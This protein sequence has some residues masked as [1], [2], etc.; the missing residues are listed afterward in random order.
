MELTVPAK[1]GETIGLDILN[2][3]SG[4][5][6]AGMFNGFAVFV[7]GAL[8]GKKVREEINLVKKNYAAG[9]L[10]EISEPSPERQEPP[11]P[12]YAACGGCQLQHLSYRGSLK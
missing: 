11:C 4:G 6:G 5:E 9:T 1:K 8:L 7:K 3:G 10:K 12:V 2:L